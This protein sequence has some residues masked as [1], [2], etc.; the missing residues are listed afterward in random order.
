MGKGGI[1]MDAKGLKRI[2]IS[3][4]I[5]KAI[6]KD[7]KGR[8]GFRQAWEE[9]DEDIQAEITCKWVEIIDEHLCQFEESLKES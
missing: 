8:S 6:L 5:Q 3:A 7:I 9:I 4:M 2:G 1:T